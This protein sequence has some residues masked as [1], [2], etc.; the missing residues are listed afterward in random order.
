LLLSF[1]LVIAVALGTAGVFAS[2]AARVEIQRAEREGEEERARR[3]EQFFGQEHVLREGWQDAQ[4][5]VRLAS[6]LS[7]LRLWLVDSRGIVVVD[8]LGQMTG[9]QLGPARYDK[10]LPLVSREGQPGT[11]FINPQPLAGPAA[12]TTSGPRPSINPYLIWGGLLAAAVALLLTLFLSGRIL[13]PLEALSR[14][15]RGLAR[16]DFTRRVRVE[17]QDEVGE[18]ARTFNSMAEELGQAEQLRR[19]L[20]A[21]VAHEL[22]TPMSNIQGFVESLQDGVM[23]ADQRTLESMHEEV[24]LLSRLVDDL[25]ELALTEAGQ[26]KLDVRQL[27]LSEM[28]RRAVAAAGPRA[29]AK[30]VRLEADLP[31]SVIVRGDGRRLA[32]VLGNL[33]ANAINY[34]PAGGRVGI[35]IASKGKEAEI[36]VT[37]T[38][39]GIPPD[40]LPHIFER[41]YRVDKSRSR[42]T[43]GVGLGLTIARRL[44]EAHGGRIAAQ[45]EVGKGSTFVV[46]LP[47][48]SGPNV[49]GQ[50]R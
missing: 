32:Q 28:A 27:D 26:L 13:A 4:T 11:L 43:G 40:E 1:A 38:G 5:M 22:R 9:R 15:A 29:E 16:G 21:D 2:Q 8:S 47:T 10:K 30:K 23:E 18:L 24:L 12:E 39:V 46:T 41:F 3:L 44:V 17:A 25:Q 50:S 49:G 42:T 34:T 14:A 37:D 20:V 19:N 48:G 6:R 31:L 36:R 35:S 45:S 7:G 33:L